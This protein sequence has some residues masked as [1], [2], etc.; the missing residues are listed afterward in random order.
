M[1]KRSRKVFMVAARFLPGSGE[2]AI[3]FRS[4]SAPHRRHDMNVFANARILA[5]LSI[6]A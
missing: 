5:G 3:I 6:P 2:P 1:E 4:F